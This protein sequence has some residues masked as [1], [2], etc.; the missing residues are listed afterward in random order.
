MV[1]ENEDSNLVLG[2]PLLVA[3][4]GGAYVVNRY[5]PTKRLWGITPN[6]WAVESAEGS[7]SVYYSAA[8]AIV[9]KADIYSIKG[10]FGGYP[11]VI[12]GRKPFG[13][14]LPYANGQSP[15]FPRKA[16]EMRNLICAVDYNLN[17]PWMGGNVAYDLWLT[18]EEFPSSPNGGVEV[19]V[20]L[21]R[22]NQ[23]PMGY[24]SGSALFMV[25]GFPT[26]FDVYIS[27]G[28][29]WSVVSILLYDRHMIQR[30]TVMLDL[31]AFIRRGLSTLGRSYSAYLQGIEFGTE[32]T[33]ADQLFTFTLS[34]FKIQQA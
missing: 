17:C 18:G 33:N 13:P 6:L 8:G 3:G 32:F 21:W 24:Y 2:R 11:E 26:R 28:F 1:A 19:M 22:R 14:N 25:N 30:G 16:S 5:I 12:Y 15:V 20:W 10:G 23:I 9:T 34:K 7:V 4:A 29:P 31:M 27:K